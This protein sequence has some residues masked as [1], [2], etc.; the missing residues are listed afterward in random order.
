MTG[1]ILNFL[2]PIIKDEKTARLASHHG[3]IVVALFMLYSLAPI[4]SVPWNVEVLFNLLGILINLPI[5]L[6]PGIAIYFCFRIGSVLLLLGLPHMD[7][8]IFTMVSGSPCFSFIP[9]NFSSLIAIASYLIIN[10]PLYLFTVNSLR[11]T[12][13]LSRMKKAKILP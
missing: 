8:F 9:P 6:I 5:F 12:F 3:L 1:K 10:F 4:F 11:G 7:M 2:W 13:A